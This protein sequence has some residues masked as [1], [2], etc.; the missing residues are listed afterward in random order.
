[1]QS[2][3]RTWLVKY[4]GILMM[5]NTVV[6]VGEGGGGGGGAGGKPRNIDFE[7]LTS[8]LRKDMV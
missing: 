1:M 2:N 5:Q 4:A 6:V 3:L 8:W 7:G